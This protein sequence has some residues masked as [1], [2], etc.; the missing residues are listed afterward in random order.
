[1]YRQRAYVG[2]E[3]CD[4]AV[5]ILDIRMPKVMGLEVLAQLKGDPSMRHLP[6]VMLTFS[7]EEADWCAATSSG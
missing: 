5:I 1:M 3:A 7:R 2:R 6:V 4:P